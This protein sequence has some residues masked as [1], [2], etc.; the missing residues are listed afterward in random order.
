MQLV[1][2]QPTEAVT[3]QSDTQQEVGGK[4]LEKS[5]HDAKRDNKQLVSEVDM[6]KTQMQLLRQ[7]ERNREEEY[8]AEMNKLRKRIGQEQEK[9]SQLKE[10]TRECDRLQ[11]RVN[12]LTSMFER[13]K[14]EAKKN[15]LQH[16]KLLKSIEL[17][18]QQVESM[19]DETN[20]VKSDCTH[21]NDELIK[22]RELISQERSKVIHLEEE[23]ANFVQKM[24]EATK[25][26][27]EFEA[28]HLKQA[29]IHEEERNNLRRMMQKVTALE[30]EKSD[31]EERS[32]VLKN[33]IAAYEKQED[34]YRQL[35][36]DS[37]DKERLSQSLQ[38][39]IIKLQNQLDDVQKQYDQNMDISNNFK[40]QLQTEKNNKGVADAALK[41]Y[42][43]K[44]AALTNENAE[45]VTAKQLATKQIK[46][47]EEQ[48][49]NTVNES[50]D[51]E[52]ETTIADLRR[53]LREAE[54]RSKVLSESNRM[55]LMR[56]KREEEARKKDAT[57]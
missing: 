54:E 15:E 18:K 48:V 46:F 26:M 37:D 29:K 34:S 20:R 9:I 14:E 51:L 2:K 55:L 53:R 41:E 38:E 30:K 32:I 33:E 52:F 42:K 27:E 40:T 10:K 36:R 39:K 22:A 44:I 4:K 47:L 8:L 7:N 43:A 25:R 17:Q 11:E 3:S 49:K 1:Q 28:V 16:K 5:L 6:L 50:K 57:K 23:K 21:A 56:L 12:K 35:R 45:L 24:K 31:L 19:Q 13:E